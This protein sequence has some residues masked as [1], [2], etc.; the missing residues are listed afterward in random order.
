MK[1]LVSSEIF[2]PGGVVTIKSDKSH[3]LLAACINKEGAAPVCA[4]ISTGHNEAV[5]PP[6]DAA[7]VVKTNSYPHPQTNTVG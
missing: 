6:S 4:A 1:I 5:K 7:A 2:S 3:F